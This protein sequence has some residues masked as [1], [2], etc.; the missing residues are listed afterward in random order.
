MLKV[1]I[2]QLP[3]CPSCLREFLQTHAAQMFPVDIKLLEGY[4]VGIQLVGIKEMLQPFPDLKLRPVLRMYFVPLGSIETAGHWRRKWVLTGS[5]N[6]MGLFWGQKSY[7]HKFHALEVH[8]LRLFSVF[9]TSSVPTA[10]E[11]HLFVVVFLL[12][13]PIKNEIYYFTPLLRSWMSR[14]EFSNVG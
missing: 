7:I 5:V 4:A 2:K 11:K 1:A 13:F 3:C 14:N 9:N 10:G 12:S 8:K 6:T